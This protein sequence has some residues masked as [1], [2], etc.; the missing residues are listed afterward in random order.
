[1]W[2]WLWLLWG[3]VCNR[4]RCV[5][6]ARG[7]SVCLLLGLISL[8]YCMPSWSSCG[9]SGDM[10]QET[11]LTLARGD[12]AGPQEGDAA[13]PKVRHAAGFQPSSYWHELLHLPFCLHPGLWK[14]I[15]AEQGVEAA[16]F[17]RHVS[18]NP[19][20]GEGTL[21][22]QLEWPGPSD[23]REQGQQGGGCGQS[24]RASPV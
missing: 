7:L 17:R 21:R 8:S 20:Q 3:L 15:K 10:S 24:L 16:M 4:K 23:R 13:V 22:F 1:M 9:L 12:A 19:E 18:K 2:L 14:R 5:T 11:A 6:I